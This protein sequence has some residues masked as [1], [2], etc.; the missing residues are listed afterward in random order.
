[1]NL[2]LKTI[3]IENFKGIKQLTVDFQDRTTVSGQNATGKTTIMDGFM[4]LLFGKDSQGKADFSIRPNDTDGKVIDNVV[5]KVTAALDVDGWELVLTKTQEQNWVKKRGSEVAQ[6][7]G[8][9]NSYEVNEIPKTEKDY[10]AYI[11]ELI[12]EE[13]FKLITSPQAFTSLKWKEQRT[14]LLELVSEVTDQDVIGTDKKFATLADMLKDVSV[15][16]LT[17][18]TKK[19]LKEL[20][21]KQAELPARIDE[22]SKGLVNADFGE[23]E[24]GK[25]ILENQIREL[26]NQ[27]GDASKIGEAMEQ[28]QNEITQKQSAIGALK[29][30]ADEK[31]IAQR[32]EIQKRIDDAEAAFMDAFRNQTR[33]ESDIQ[34][35][36]E[37]LEGYRTLREAL[38]KK[39]KDTVAMEMDVSD[40]NCPM[41]GQALP[42][43]QRETKV[44]E[45]RENKQKSL[46]DIVSTGKKAAADI[47][48]LGA[49]IK[50]LE[51][52]LAACKTDKIEQNGL[53]TAAMKELEEQMLNEVDLTKDGEYLTLW[54]EIEQLRTKARNME[55]GSDY[56]EQIRQQKADLV[57]ELDKVKAV[58]S[59]KDNNRRVQDRVAEL[60][61][62]QRSVAQKIANQEKGLFLLEEFTKA[63]MDMLSSRINAKFKLV[64]FRLFE[65][66]LN[67]GYKETCE[68]MV[69]GVPFN[70]LNSG[71]RVIAGLDIISAL[72]EIYG[73]TAPIFI[74]NAESINDFNIPAT[75]GQLILLKVSSH[76]QLKVEV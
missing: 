4:W 62:E 44:A 2:K 28:I 35:K 1:L 8:N 61:Q 15:D 26:E 73:V 51:E 39:H 14:I 31:A 16:D 74:D 68:C 23:F 70:S 22:A 12:S 42:V 59:G 57:A 25:K 58:L 66:Q 54:E 37:L 9:V 47:A 48:A 13:L 52:Q 67:G 36:G 18:K 46:D 38:L 76:R 30:R 55:S 34:H 6:L 7:Q 71:H 56:L 27:Q 49:E 29:R 50:A 24:E 69:G 17:A 60:Q 64:N 21:K 19:A 43:D 40:C 5:I 3:C 63:K 53:K 11:S 10:K 65:D 41:C 32:R 33:I 45:F 75:S 72:Q 20:N